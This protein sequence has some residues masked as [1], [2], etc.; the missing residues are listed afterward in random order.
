MKIKLEQHF[1]AIAEV[2]NPPLG[3]TPS[4]GLTSRQRKYFRDLTVEQAQSIVHGALGTFDPT[5]GWTTAFQPAW[6]CSQSR[7]MHFD[8]LNGTYETAPCLPCYRRRSSIDAT[9]KV[10]YAPESKRG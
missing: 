8:A 1:A 7:K 4:D 6:N 3:R 5:R 10:F 9:P 2:I